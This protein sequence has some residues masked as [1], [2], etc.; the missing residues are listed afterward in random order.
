LIILA[1]PFSALSVVKT[2]INDRC[3]PLAKRIKIEL[4]VYPEG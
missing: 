1:V 2:T 3:D 4:A